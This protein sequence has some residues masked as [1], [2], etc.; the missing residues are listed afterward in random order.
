MPELNGGAAFAVGFLPVD[1]FPRST[2]NRLQAR[3][4]RDSDLN[5]FTLTDDWTAGSPRLREAIASYLGVSRN[6]SCEKDNVLIVPSAQAAFDLCAR[7]LADAGDK[8][9]FENPGY[10]GAR[11]ALEANG[12]DLVPVP[13]DGSGLMVKVGRQ[14]APKAR[15]AY[16][17]PSHQCPTGAT[18]SLQRRIELLEW[19][20]END[21]WIIEDDYDSEY[22]F[23][24]KPIAAV[25][26]L[27]ENHKVIYVGT[28]SKTMLPSVKVAYLVVP[29]PVLP[30]FRRALA[31]LGHYPAPMLQA[32]LAEFITNGHF[33]SNLNKARAVALGRRARLAEVLKGH[34]RGLDVTLPDGGLSFPVWFG[35]RDEAALAADCRQA[36]L[37]VRFI[38]RYYLGEPQRSGLLLGCAGVGGQALETAARRLAAII[39]RHAV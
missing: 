30:A 25:Q 32:A 35:Y 2:W 10:S 38:G 18:L 19:A 37:T 4:A 39:Q 9:W 13:V 31:C 5:R 16:V 23:S 17:T 14:R 26:G 15:L 3:H 22:R 34:C 12:L 28:F 27:D 29:D 7:L 36:Q 24:G 33:F 21:A 1:T 20:A 8:V 11:S 6:V